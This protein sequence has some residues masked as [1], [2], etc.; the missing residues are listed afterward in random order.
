MSSKID[1]AT[2]FTTAI[3]IVLI[4]VLILSAAHIL[5]PPWAVVGSY[6]MVPTLE[7]GDIVVLAQPPHCVSCL[8]GKVIVYS[9]PGMPWYEIVHRVIKVEGQY[10]RT[11]GDANPIPDAWR[12]TLQNVRGVVIFVIPHIGLI[13]LA[14]KSGVGGIV[15]CILGL[16]YMAV[17][18]VISKIVD[19]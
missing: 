13:A 9:M 2:V 4:A 7:I 14:V 5:T 10:M 12:I 18:Y 19:K 17:L 1:P 11:K 8:L 15:L 16:L 3:L 6:S